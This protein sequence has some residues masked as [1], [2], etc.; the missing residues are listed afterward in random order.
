MSSDNTRNNVN[1][2]RFRD[3]G[4]GCL[5]TWTCWGC[6]VRRGSTLGAKGVGFKRRCAAC[7]ESKKAAKA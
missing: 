3:V 2:V 1:D 6:N 7:V 4:T 5:M